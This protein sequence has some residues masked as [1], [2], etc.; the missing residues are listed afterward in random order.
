MLARRAETLHCTWGLQKDNSV[1]A[2]VCFGGVRVCQGHDEAVTQSG[3]RDAAAA[4]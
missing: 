2:C 3:G 1:C 4:D